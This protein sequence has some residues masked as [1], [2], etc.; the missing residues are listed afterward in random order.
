MKTL[1]VTL[2]QHTPLLHFQH[3]QEGATLRASE[4][5]PKLDKFL[6]IKLGKE[7]YENG[8]NVAKEKGWLIGKREHPALNY[9]MRIETSGNKEEYLIASNLNRNKIGDLVNNGINVLTPTP[10]FAQEKE[11]GIIANT[12]NREAQKEA[13]DKTKCK[14]VKHDCTIVNI[15]SVSNGLIEEIAGLIQEFFVANNF[16]TRQNKGFGSYTVLNGVITSNGEETRTDIQLIDNDTLLRKAFSIYYKKEL[17]NATLGKIFSTI[18]KDYKLLKSG[19]N[20][21]YAKPKLMLYGKRYKQRWEKKFIKDH[22]YNNYYINKNNNEVYE[23]KGNNKKFLRGINVD[24]SYYFLR[25]L[26]GL[27]GQ[28]EFQLE[29]P[30]FGIKR[31]KAIITVYSKNV[32]RFQSPIFFKVIDSTIY[33]L[34]NEIPKEILDQEFEFA[35]SIEKDKN[36]KN[37]KIKDS[38]KTPKEFSLAEFLKFAKIDKELGYTT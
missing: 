30:P 12:E 16:G 6:L 23:L 35:V 22:F 15:W 27:A 24:E 38:I 33:L 3:N 2:R 9:K 31:N 36:N 8:K 21:P 19:I 13:W 37:K 17:I 11:N 7:N 32:E 5:K 28:Y 20:K 29:N 34:A 25:A 1:T 10:Y 4:V 18:T 26:L 14:G